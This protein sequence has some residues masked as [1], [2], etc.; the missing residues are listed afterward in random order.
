[1]SHVRSFGTC[2]PAHHA[3]SRRGFLSEGAVRA[4]GAVT[5]AGCFAS[6]MGQIHALRSEEVASE[7]RNQD[8]R[9]ILLW[10]AGGASQFETWDPKPGAR[11]AVHFV[12]FR[13]TPLEF[14]SANCFPNYLNGC[15]IR[16][17]SD[18]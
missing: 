14:T 12:R 8:K 5:V 4:A 13:R 17:L 16:Q 1:M 18:L 3:V 11:P 6:D 2:I 7:L 10:L 15:I 9:V